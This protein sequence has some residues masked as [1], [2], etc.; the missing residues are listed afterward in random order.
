MKHGMTNT[1]TF[2]FWYRLRSRYPLCERWADFIN[3]YKD[4]GAKPEGFYLRRKN[5]SIAYS[6]DNCEWAIGRT[7]KGRISSGNVKVTDNI[8]IAWEN[9]RSYSKRGIEIVND[10]LKFDNFHRDMG[11][12][13]ERSRLT[14]I[15][16]SKGYSKENCKWSIANGKKGE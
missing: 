12:R 1:K 8:F 14:R 7:S 13:P 10:W 4:M 5:I 16:K 15:D 11:D 2:N 3:F 6:K 9:M